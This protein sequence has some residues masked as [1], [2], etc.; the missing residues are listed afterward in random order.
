M[1]GLFSN[2]EHK[3]NITCL[4]TIATGNKVERKKYKNKKV[5]KK[6]KSHSLPITPLMFVFF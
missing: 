6:E 2:P 5:R 1:L 3:P 4:Q